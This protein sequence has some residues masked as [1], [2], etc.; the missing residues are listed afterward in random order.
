MRLSLATGI[1]CPHCRHEMVVKTKGL[2]G[3]IIRQVVRHMQ[4]R[5]LKDRGGRVHCPVC[6]RTFIWRN[7]PKRYLGMEKRG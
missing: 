3:G 4:I 7:N 5:E 6:S 2:L 1:K